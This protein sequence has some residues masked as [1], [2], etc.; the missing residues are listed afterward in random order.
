[1]NLQLVFLFLYGVVYLY[2]WKLLLDVG[3]LGYL[4]PYAFTWIASAFFC[5]L[6]GRKKTFPFLAF[7]MGS[8]F[9]PIGVIILL[10]FKK[11]IRLLKDSEKGKDFYKLTLVQM[12]KKIRLLMAKETILAQ[13]AGDA[14]PALQLYADY[15]KLKPDLPFSYKLTIDEYKPLET[16]VLLREWMKILVEFNKEYRQRFGEAMPEIDNLVRQIQEKGVGLTI[17]LEQKEAGHER[18]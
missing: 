13:Y 6:I 14:I 15:C 12:E 7:F 18:F 9:G 17:S 5:F 8:V 4:K 1:M 3:N 11:D 2:G 16:R 10:F